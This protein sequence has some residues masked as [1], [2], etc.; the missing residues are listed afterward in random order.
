M[1]NWWNGLKLIQQKGEI[2]LVVAG[3]PDTGEQDQQ[4]IDDLLKRLLQDLP[5]KP[6]SQLAADL[7]GL[8]KNE[9]YQRALILK[10]S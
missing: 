5:V 3:K 9:L 10:E 8:K 6:A 4:K 2:V 7:T 1:A